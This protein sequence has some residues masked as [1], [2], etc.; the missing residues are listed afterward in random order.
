MCRQHAFVHLNQGQLTCNDA[1]DISK[2]CLVGTSNAGVGVG[3]TGVEYV[4]PPA[5][6][7]VTMSRAAAL[8]ERCC[9]A[10]CKRCHA[11]TLSTD[12]PHPN[13]IFC[14][15][16]ENWRRPGRKQCTAQFPAQTTESG[17]SVGTVVWQEVWASMPHTACFKYAYKRMA[18]AYTIMC[19]ATGYICSRIHF[20]LLGVSLH[21]ISTPITSNVRYADKLL[22][23]PQTV[24]GPQ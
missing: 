13:S 4:A 14:G 24:A 2:G 16:N 15:Y 3:Y 23:A 18:P 8:R 11:L 22:R 7:L 10:T 21:V 9:K 6:G 19:C 5:S 1:L 12:L 17:P 20:V